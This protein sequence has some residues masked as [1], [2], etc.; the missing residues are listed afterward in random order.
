MGWV[1]NAT[2]RPLYPREKPSTYCIVG[3]VGPSAGLVG[4]EKCRPTGI[5]SPDRPAR[6]E[7]LYR[8]SYP[9]PY[10]FRLE[11]NNYIIIRK[12]GPCLTESEFKKKK[13]LNQIWGSNF[14]CPYPHNKSNK[15]KGKAYRRPSDATEAITVLD[16]ITV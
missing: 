5:R 3:W 7:S 16:N 12:L 15:Q 11:G 4:C 8:L 13:S 6:S 10:A 14:V 1:V 2:P 9:G